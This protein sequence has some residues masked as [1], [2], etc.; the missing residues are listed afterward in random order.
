MDRISVFFTSLFLIVFLNNAHSQTNSLIVD[1]ALFKIDTTIKQNN[2]SFIFWRANSDTNNKQIIIER[3]SKYNDTIVLDVAVKDGDYYLSDMNDDGYVDF[4]SLYH[5]GD[6]IHFFN[7]KKN[8]FNK[9]ALWMAGR[10]GSITS[11]NANFHY[12]FYDAMYGSPYAFS[13]L[14][15]YNGETPYFYY[16]IKYITADTYGDKDSTIKINLYRF[17]NGD[18]GQEVFVKEIKTAHPSKFDY[19]KYWLQHYKQLLNLK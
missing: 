2:A 9:K 15:K 17:K 18:F 11:P 4:V 16:E 7:K 6:V 3:I 5:E 12:D 1:T 14:Y 19:E 8:S 10:S 13:S